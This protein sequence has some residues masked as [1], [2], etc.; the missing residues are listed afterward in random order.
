[1]IRIALAVAEHHPV[2]K[3]GKPCGVSCIAQDKVCHR[4]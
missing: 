3:V 1:M 4:P 2:C